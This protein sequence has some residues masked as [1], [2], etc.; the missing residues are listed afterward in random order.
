M[1]SERPAGDICLGVS[2]PTPSTD[3]TLH[4][5]PATPD[6]PPAGL[7]RAEVVRLL[8][9]AHREHLPR[10]RLTEGYDTDEVDAF[11]DRLERELPLD[12]PSMSA[13]EIR[14]L[15]FTPVRI[16]PGY[17][18]G[19]VDKLLDEV[20]RVLDRAY[21]GGTG[22]VTPHPADV[23]RILALADR[24]LLPRSLLA[25]GYD[26]DEVDA[27][28]ARL[29]R[30][31]PLDPPAITAEEVRSL[32]FTPVRMKTA[33]PVGDIDNLLDDCIRVLEGRGKFQ[34]L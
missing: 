13:A 14:D 21:G 29:E 4:A 20:A 2:A 17:R 23:G 33:Y 10:T 11:L 12:P 9:M 8:R 25:E 32:E 30:D 7:P 24:G 6:R 27:F 31:L 1:V 28:L 15:R 3:D 26:L 34:G 5:A 19:D 18:M 22:V 16:R